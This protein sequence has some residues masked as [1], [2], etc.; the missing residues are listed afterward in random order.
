MIKILIKIQKLHNLPTGELRNLIY[1][2]GKILDL[3]KN[4]TSSYSCIYPH[5]KCSTTNYRRKEG[6][7]EVRK[8]WKERGEQGR[9]VMTFEFWEFFNIF[10]YLT[11]L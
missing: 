5:D 1:F 9:L 7:E 2:E 6:R 3:W 10:Q 11:V 4:G 8:E